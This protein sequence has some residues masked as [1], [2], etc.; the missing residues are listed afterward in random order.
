M[1]TA[2]VFATHLKCGLGPQGPVI[3]FRHPTWMPPW[4]RE[5]E[6]DEDGDVSVNDLK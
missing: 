3:E 2:W 1:P 4:K 5:I 6:E